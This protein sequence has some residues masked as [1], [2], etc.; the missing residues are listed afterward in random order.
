MLWMGIWVHPY[1]EIHVQVGLNFRDNGVLMSL[2]DGVVSWLR[3]QTPIYCI[4]HP[5]W[6]YTKWFSTLRCCGWA[7]G[8]ILI[9]VL[10]VQVG[11]NFRENGVLQSLYDCDVIVEAA[12]PH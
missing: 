2:H 5:Y 4:T 8:C 6:M 9:N 10:H 3:L 1:A 7:Y 11:V 12:N